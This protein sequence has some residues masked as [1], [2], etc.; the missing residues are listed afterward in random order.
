MS[1]G[2]PTRTELIDVL[3]RLRQSRVCA[4]HGSFACDCKAGGGDLCELH[5]FRTGE[6]NG[7]FEL[8]LA[9][10]LFSRMT[11]EEYERLKMTGWKSDEAHEAQH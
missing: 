1:K 6:E 4:Y 10:Y 8:R 3:D 11:D 7:C 5:P 9:S 2:N